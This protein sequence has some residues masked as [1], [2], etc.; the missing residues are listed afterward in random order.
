MKEIKRL[1]NKIYEN[2]SGSC[3]N[4]EYI[5]FSNGRSISKDD[6]EEW[7]KEYDMLEQE[8]ENIKEEN[9]TDDDLYKM[10]D[11]FLTSKGYEGMIYCPDPDIKSVDQFVIMK[12]REI[13]SEEE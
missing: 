6:V 8:F 7:I 13:E 12:A 2:T 11:D 9:W 4:E 3:T 5:D 1:M 10:L